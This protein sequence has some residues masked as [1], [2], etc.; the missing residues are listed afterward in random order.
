MISEGDWNY[1]ETVVKNLG[2]KYLKSY[3]E[4]IEAFD[5]KLGNKIPNDLN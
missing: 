4:F 2:Q 5:A 3:A 1:D